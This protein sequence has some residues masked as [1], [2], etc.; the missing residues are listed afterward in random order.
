[1]PFDGVLEVSKVTTALV[2]AR[3]RLE[4]GWSRYHARSREGVCLAMAL[5]DS[6]RDVDVNVFLLAKVIDQTIDIKF[7]GIAAWNASHTKEEV[8]AACNKA[9]D[10]SLNVSVDEYA[11]AA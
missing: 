8:I 1:M 4:R 10:I 6:A 3:D 7:G 5:C 11:L 9:I 2:A